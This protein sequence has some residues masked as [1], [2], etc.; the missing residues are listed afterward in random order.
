MSNYAE[1]GGG[2]FITGSGSS[3]EPYDGEL[4]A[5]FEDCKFIGNKAE[6]TGGAIESAIGAAAITKTS[7]KSNE[8]GVGGALRL[9]G[10]SSV[11]GC[12]F[13]ENLSDLGGGQAISWI[14]YYLDI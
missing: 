3:L 12:T 6:A 11:K 8:A 13:E 2:V 4:S 9:A 14:G 10:V 1:I 7:F 5:S